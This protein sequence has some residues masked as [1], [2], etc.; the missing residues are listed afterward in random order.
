MAYEWMWIQTSLPKEV[1]NILAEDARQFG[2]STEASTVFSGKEEKW[3]IV[4]EKTRTSRHSWIPETHWIA[5]FVMHY[6]NVVND[7]NYRYDLTGLDSH[8]LQYGIYG[9]GGHYTW[10]NDYGIANCQEYESSRRH[11]VHQDAANNFVVSSSETVRKLSFSL[12][13]TEASEYEGGDL[14]IVGVNGEVQKMQKEFGTIIFF[15]S[16]V[17]HRVTPV[18]KGER[19]SIV[20]WVVGP[21]W[22]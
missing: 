16:R 18:T 15:D 14:E 13:L 2:Q 22:R 5:G 7:K 4:D 3:Q 20:G 1:M 8:Q 6:A 10:H 12:Q 17:I 19:R 11:G 9:V 21:R